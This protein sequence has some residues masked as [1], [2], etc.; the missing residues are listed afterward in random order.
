M[1]ATQLK[2]PVTIGNGASRNT[3]TVIHTDVLRGHGLDDDAELYAKVVIRMAHPGPAI[4]LD[5]ALERLDTTSA[6]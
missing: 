2:N 5:E 6:H 1:T 3:T 4:S